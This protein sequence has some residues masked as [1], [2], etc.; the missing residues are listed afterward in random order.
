MG[1]DMYLNAKRYISGYKHSKPESQEACRAALEAAGLTAVASDESQYAEVEACAI[2][3]R[4]ANAIHRWFV[5]N[6]QG[7]NDDCDRYYVSREKLLELRAACAQVL[8]VAEIVEGQPC[9]TSTTYRAG[10][11]PEPHFEMGRAL[12]NGEKAAEVLPTQAG[13]FFGGTD[14]DEGYQDLEHTIREIDR[15]LA[16]LP[17]FAHLEYHANRW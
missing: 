17:E 6:V 16:A 1:L 15:V 9:H 4:K 14:Y 8:G 3:W 13:F 11:E 12:L 10:E 5:E 7:G 2:Y